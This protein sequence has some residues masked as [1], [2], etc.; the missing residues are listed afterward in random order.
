MESTTPI[1]SQG[2]AQT[3]ADAVQTTQ[4]SHGLVCR[5]GSTTISQAIDANMASYAGRDETRGQRMAWWRQEIG[6]IRLDSVDQDT[7]FFALEKLQSRTPRYWAGKDADGNN[8]Y[9]AKKTGYAPAT[10]NRYAATIG[11]LFTWCFRNR[12]TPKGWE[13]PCRGIERK[14]EKNERTR[15]LSES[16]C[17]A[18]LSACKASRWPK[19]YLLVLM[20]IVT[21]GRRTEIRRLTWSDIDWDRKEASVYKTKNDTPKVMPLTDSVM[22]EL[23]KFRGQPSALIFASSQCPWQP[24]NHVPVWSKALKDAGIKN[25]KFHDLR[26]TCASY[27][28]QQGAT[29]IQIGEVLGQKQVSVTKRYSHLT[30]AHKS[31]LIHDVLGK[32]S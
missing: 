7:I 31:R 14:A 19:L 15:F 5:S 13:H 28:A 11:A 27:L 6:H 10:I 26:H 9:K 16:E 25:F 30:T 17:S 4:I 32:I 23:A 8:I 24:Y 22:N 2:I 29:L 12:L 1:P 18:L 21:G 3:A 20:G